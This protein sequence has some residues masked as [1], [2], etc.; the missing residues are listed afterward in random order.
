MGFQSFALDIGSTSYLVLSLV[1]I[2]LMQMQDHVH[3]TDLHG[4]LQ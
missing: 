2:F 4:G 1:L 3:Y